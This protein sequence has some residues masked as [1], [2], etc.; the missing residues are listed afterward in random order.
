M[1][2]GWKS[3]VTSIHSRFFL[4]IFLSGVIGCSQQPVYEPRI[5]RALSPLSQNEQNQNPDASN[6]ANVPSQEI[7]KARISLKDN[8]T[9][10]S[11]FKS[12]KSF[13]EYVLFDSVADPQTA[14]LKDVIGIPAG[15]E[16]LFIVDPKLCNAISSAS[17]L[18]GPYAEQIKAAKSEFALSI[19]ITEKITAK[20]FEAGLGQLG[21]CVVGVTDNAAAG[22]AGSSVSSDARGSHYANI[23]FADGYTKFTQ[24]IGN[25][26]AIVTV[27]VLD[28]GL[29]ALPQFDR[30][31]PFTTGRNY[32]EG[33]DMPTDT[34]GHGTGVAAVIA[35]KHD[36][37][38]G[39][40]GMAWPYAQ[41]LPIRLVSGNKSS[42]SIPMRVLFNAVQHLTNAKADVVNMSF[43][44]LDKTHCHPAFMHVISRGIER[45]VFYVF[46]AG[47]GLE[48]GPDGKMIPGPIISPA[49]E[50]PIAFGKTNAP[51]CAGRLFK[52]AL[53]VSSLDAE[54]KNLASHSNWGDAV[55]VLAQGERI[56]TINAAGESVFQQGTSLAAPQVA[57]AA[58]MTIAY[59][60]KHGRPYTPWLIED[61]LLN[62]FPQRGSLSELIHKGRVLDFKGLADSVSDIAGKSDANLSQIS[63]EDVNSNKGENLKDY[64]KTR[65]IHVTG[66]A[67]LKSGGRTQLRSIAY[68]NAF[69]Y[70]VVTNNT[71][72]TV[73]GTGAQV[74]PEGV[75]I[76]SADAK[77]KFD[78]T[79]TYDGHS[80][81]ITIHVVNID[82]ITGTNA[83]LE[84]LELVNLPEVATPCCWHDPANKIHYWSSLTS[85]RLPFGI[86]ARYDNG[87]ERDVTEFATVLSSAEKEMS[88][89][90]HGWQTD[91]AY[92]GKDYD[93]TV[94][95]DGKSISKKIKVQKI[96][97][98]LSDLKIQMT[99]FDSE[100]MHGDSAP[101]IVTGNNSPY[102]WGGG[103]PIDSKFSIYD[104]N[105]TF[106][107]R[108]TEVVA[109]RYKAGNYSVEF[110]GIYRGDGSDQNITLRKNLSIKES[111]IVDVVLA[112]LSDYSATINFRG[113]RANKLTDFIPE[114]DKTFRILD[115][116]GKVLKTAGV[117]WADF[118]QA[119]KVFEQTPGETL[120]LEATYLPLQLKKT[121]Q[122]IY[123]ED[124]NFKHRV[125]DPA[126]VYVLP[127]KIT[128]PTPCTTAN[129]SAPTPPAGDG[130]QASPFLICSFTQLKSLKDIFKVKGDTVK[131]FHIYAALGKDLDLSD[132][133]DF[134]GFDFTAGTKLVS[135]NRFFTFDGNGYTI[136]NL[137]M[138]DAESGG[139]AIAGVGLLWSANVKMNIHNLNFDNATVRGFVNVGVIAPI[140][141][142]ESVIDNVTI[143]NSIVVG[144]QYVGGAVGQ[145]WGTVRN[146]T[147]NKVQI[148]VSRGDAGIIAGNLT[149]RGV[150]LI[151]NATVEGRVDYIGVPGFQGNLGG[152][153]GSIQGDCQ[154]LPSDFNLRQSNCGVLLDVSADVKIKGAY[155]IDTVRNP[156]GA[157]VPEA[158]VGGIAG[159]VQDGII[160]RSSAQGE[161][162]NTGDTVG[163][164]AGVLTSGNFNSQH[165]A[166]IFKTNS[167]V[168]VLAG[169]GVQGTSR[170][171]GLVGFMNNSYLE[172]SSA[173]GSVYGHAAV[174]GAVGEFYENNF[175]FNVAVNGAQNAKTTEV[176]T[177]I[178][179]ISGGYDIGPISK[180]T[181]IYPLGGFKDNTWKA[182]ATSV[183]KKVGLY[184]R[185]REIQNF[186]FLELTPN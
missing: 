175:I 23:G 98:R 91:N 83:K 131:E 10:I 77:G 115:A 138:I 173:N 126:T 55:E 155:T 41:L 59:F 168:N 2:T 34:S 60:K 69:A 33:G 184:D 45:G 166:V 95:Y 148:Q 101:L 140:L 68:A 13:L 112:Q 157:G 38:S 11:P 123:R 43:G 143:Q 170:V 163:G 139:S 107:H 117:N 28:S 179:R 15:T 58:A 150:G 122:F 106:L 160:Y 154:R 165:S 79:A 102:V 142:P 36:P 94:L 4:L 71:T 53:T 63:T 185:P 26:P 86:K 169:A 67:F 42:E 162:M 114:Q 78:V 21:D 127:G 151:E 116:S 186:D 39:L 100:L 29:A 80:H 85:N 119:L 149:G 14:E 70:K 105:G 124:R 27:G 47:N 96:P 5:K 52:G 134:K 62:A 183:T 57:A 176:G 73:N 31:H 128:S 6:G 182:K 177:F 92:G 3:I 121:V 133:T 76:A 18:L 97:L 172:K 137:T 35:A 87:F 40:F 89:S 37:N 171:G 54:Y 24:L 30:I 135:G 153:V 48:I 181:K 9:L 167:S 72:W 88:A 51:A 111:P 132:V 19:K 178:G 90:K 84:K 156:T 93:F 180:S 125:G 104:S 161:I 120:T 46:S 159:R 65:R 158:G 44:I 1:Y 8:L 22:I 64:D 7:Q 146:F 152:V 32:V 61:I 75:F 174:G 17:F 66:I 129:S 108:L 12:K 103:G 145:V 118:A 147:A 164:I 25:A 109:S 144:E 81:T 130:S 74:T 49:L 136:R 110:T 56:Q 141:G 50:G 99:G 20:D 16:S 113:I 82:L